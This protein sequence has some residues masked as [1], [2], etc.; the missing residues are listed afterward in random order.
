VSRTKVHDPGMVA[1]GIL[2]NAKV[3]EHVHPVEHTVQTVPV[4]QPVERQ[5]EVK[6]EV[7]PINRTEVHRHIHPI[8]KEII[9]EHIHP[10]EVTEVIENIHERR[11]TEIHEHQHP[12]DIK[13]VRKDVYLPEKR[14]IKEK[15]VDLGEVGRE[16]VDVDLGTHMHQHGP[17]M[18]TREAH[19]RSVPHTHEHAHKK[20]KKHKHD[21]LATQPNAVPK[22]IDVDVDY[23]VGKH[24]KVKH[25][26]VHTDVTKRPDL[27]HSVGKDSDKMVDVDLNIKKGK[28]H[29]AHA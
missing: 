3:V 20:H 18:H 29:T 5:V 6:R 10:K 19:V 2:N 8:E 27:K 13:E 4:Y 25:K 9:K 21:K 1:R 12:R 28:E 17:E 15:V 7:I 11:T 23:D 26:E 22:Q 24:G 16:R 14:I